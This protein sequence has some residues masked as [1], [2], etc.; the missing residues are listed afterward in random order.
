MLLKDNFKR[1][2]KLKSLSINGFLVYHGI[3]YLCPNFQIKLFKV[4]FSHFAHYKKY[5]E[6]TGKITLLWRLMNSLQQDLVEFCL[7]FILFFEKWLNILGNTDC[8][9]TQQWLKG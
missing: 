6:S 7:I 8:L 1:L 9:D 5:K 3:H 4:T 2:L